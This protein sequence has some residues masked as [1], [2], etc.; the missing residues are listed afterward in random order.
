MEFEIIEGLGASLHHV[1]IGGDN[2]LGIVPIPSILSEGIDN[3]SFFGEV[4]SDRGG[5]AG[6][7]SIGNFTKRLFDSGFVAHSCLFSFRRG[8]S[9]GRRGSSGGC[10]SR[11]SV[12]GEYGRD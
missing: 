8:G 4:R 11:S 1:Q 9:S 12:I 2:L 5:I 6:G 7:P 10:G 3:R